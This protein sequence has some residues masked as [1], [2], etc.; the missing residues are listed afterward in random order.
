M[1][2]LTRLTNTALNRDVLQNLQSLTSK[3]HTLVKAQAT[4]QSIHAISEDPATISQAIHY[5][6]EKRNL[7]QMNRNCVRVDAF[8]NITHGTLRSIY[9][10]LERGQELAAYS[11]SEVNRNNL[12][13][14]SQEVEGLV[15]QLA[16]QLNQRYVTKYLFSAS[17]AYEAPFLIEK[18]EEGKIQKVDYQGGKENPSEI[19]VSEGTKES[20]FLEADKTQKLLA[21]MQHM[22]DLR[23]SLHDGDIDHVKNVQKALTV[24]EYNLNQSMSSLAARM[25]KMKIINNNNTNAFTAVERNLSNL[26]DVDLFTTAAGIKNI[27]H[28][29]EMS[30]KV[31]S[32]LLNKTNTL[33]D[34]L[35]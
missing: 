18:D 24:D 1:A 16:L 32:M 35:F 21:L 15:N 25:Q 17:K 20:G 27:E 29:L 4:G 26:L 33:M 34:F 12:F 8:L 11:S 7:I 30:L 14:Y 5:H 13:A 23:N 9:E 3:Q 2:N 10:L 28:T 6:T 31:S 22:L 19:F